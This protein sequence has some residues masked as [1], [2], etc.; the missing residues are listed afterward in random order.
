MTALDKHPTGPVVAIASELLQSA[1]PWDHNEL[2]R[3]VSNAKPDDS[4]LQQLRFRD[5]RFDLDNWEGPSA[6]EE[7]FSAFTHAMAA[8]PEAQAPNTS[9][10]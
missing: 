2:I 5:P 6:V 10:R 3:A 7:A 8:A 4:H 9:G 1:F